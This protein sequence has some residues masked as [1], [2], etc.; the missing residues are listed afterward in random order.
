MSFS[1]PVEIQLP[2]GQWSMADFQ[3]EPARA[4]EAAIEDSGE[5]SG[6]TFTQS[7]QK[8]VAQIESDGSFTVA[9]RDDASGNVKIIIDQG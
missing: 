8:L 6:G 1:G 7:L 9:R 2:Q 5:H 3:N 4:L